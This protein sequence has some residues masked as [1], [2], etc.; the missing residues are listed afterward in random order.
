M[1]GF[2]KILF[3]SVRFCL[4]L[5][6]ALDI[7]SLVFF[8]NDWIDNFDESLSEGFFIFFLKENFFLG[9]SSF[10]LTLGSSYFLL[11]NMLVSIFFY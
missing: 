11:L 5:L 9:F 10:S 3:L 8:I 7:D 2:L 1:T 6:V 4:L